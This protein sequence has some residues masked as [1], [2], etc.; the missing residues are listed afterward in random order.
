MKLSIDLRSILAF[1][2]RRLGW[3]T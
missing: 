1:Y 3:D 2:I